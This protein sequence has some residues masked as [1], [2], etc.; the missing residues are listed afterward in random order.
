MQLEVKSVGYTDD[1]Y[2]FLWKF[3]VF[4]KNIVP[5]P[6]RTEIFKFLSR[7]V[8]TEPEN[9]RPDPV[10]RYGTVRAGSGFGSRRSCLVHS[11]YYLLYFI[12]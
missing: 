6:Y 3:W 10:P 11:R 5:V 12:L 4:K 9:F 7:T 2:R 8:P 1:M